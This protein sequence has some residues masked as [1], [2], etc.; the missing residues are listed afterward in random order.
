M[1]TFAHPF[2]FSPSRDEDGR[3]DVSFHSFVTAYAQD[4]LRHIMPC[5]SSDSLGDESSKRFQDTTRIKANL[6]TSHLDSEG[7]V[8]SGTLAAIAR[9]S[10]GRLARSA[11]QT[12]A[13]FLLQADPQLH[14]PPTTV[15]TAIFNLFGLEAQWVSSKYFPTEFTIYDL[16]YPS[17]SVHFI[18]SAAE[19]I[20]A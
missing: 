18:F 12:L 7:G 9:K 3:A 14:G 16:F 5:S 17:S 20:G 6:R 4:L 2:V 19:L 8:Q 13:E 15:I 10:V 1:V 11:R